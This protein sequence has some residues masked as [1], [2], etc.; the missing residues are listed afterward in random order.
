MSTFETAAQ[1]VAKA[2]QELGLGAISIS[3]GVDDANGYQTLGLLNSLGDEVLRAHDWENL[4]RTMTFTGDG[5]TTEFPMPTDFGRQVNQTQWATSDQRPMQGP[6]SP[7]VWS[8]C[9]YGIVA[10]G[11]YFWYRILRGKYAV[12]PAPG[13][14]VDFALYYIGKNWVEKDITGYKYNLTSPPVIENLNYN[15]VADYGD[16][17]LHNWTPTTGFA[18]IVFNISVLPGTLNNTT[19]RTV[20]VLEESPD[21]GATWTLSQFYDLGHYTGVLQSNVPVTEDMD[22]V[23]VGVTLQTTTTHVRVVIGGIDLSTG[24]SAG[25][26]AAAL[27]LTSDLVPTN[28]YYVGQ[29]IALPYVL[30]SS[31]TAAG[32]IPQ[33]DSRMLITGL[34]AKLWAQKGFDTTVLQKEFNYMLDSEKAMVQGAKVI[35]LSGDSSYFLLGYGNVPDGTTYGN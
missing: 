20:V 11:F 1:I 18:S 15:L 21:G 27:F 9:Q 17:Q 12:F 6:V 5:T 33:F 22:P 30:G 16:A 24:T 32:D 7:Q 4:E 34:K 14:G 29:D 31:I 35:N 3:A 10:I 13:D 26:L 2:A 25:V 8:W 19:N 23:T 28:T